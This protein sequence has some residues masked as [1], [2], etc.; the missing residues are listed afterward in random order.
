MNLKKDT[1]KI[2]IISISLIS[3]F[4]IYSFFN[5]KLYKISVA[6]QGTHSSTSSYSNINLTASQK[7]ADFQ[8]MYD[9]LI[10]NYPYFGVNERVNNINWT[11]QKN[12]F[13]Q[14]IKKTTNDKEFKDVLTNIIKELNNNHTSLLNKKDYEYWKNLY[15]TEPIICKPWCDILYQSEVVKRYSELEK[16]ESKNFNPINLNSFNNTKVFSTNIIIPEKLAYIHISSFYGL[17]TKKDTEDI[18]NFFKQIKNFEYLIIDIRGN[19]GGDNGYWQNNL[20]AP[21]INEPISFNNYFLIRGGEYSKK[22]ID[23]KKIKLHNIKELDR[24]IMKNSHQEVFSDFKYYGELNY[25]V[26]PRNPVDFKGKIFLIVDRYVYSSAETF[27]VFCKATKWATV[28]GEQTAG[29]GVGI[30]PFMLSL[31]NSGY[32]VRF[33]GSYGLNP[34]GSSNEEVKTTPDILVD[35]TVGKSFEEDLAIQKIINLINK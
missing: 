34:D 27:S 26:N 23:A 25:I 29:D 11:I 7:I 19:N 20:V 15:I 4:V 16:N 18:Y 21:L 13:I 2:I 31:P 12:N 17:N 8:Y 14:Q 6:N 24:K 32:I 22:F 5:G 1:K 35:A 28:V 9:I 30:D 3:I 10:E 33:A